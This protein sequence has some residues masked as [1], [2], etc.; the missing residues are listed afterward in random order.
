MAPRCTPC[1]WWLVPCN[2]ASQGAE[3][4]TSS[5]PTMQKESFGAP[6]NQGATI[7]KGRFTTVIERSPLP[8]GTCYS[9]RISA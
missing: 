9:A 5:L 3:V 8:N 6:K 7:R 2:F 4:S 1:C